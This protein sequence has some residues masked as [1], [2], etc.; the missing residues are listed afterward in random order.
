M[1]VSDYR[2]GEQHSDA[3]A[4][5][6]HERTDERNARCDAEG[7]PGSRQAKLPEK[8]P[9]ERPAQWRADGDGEKNRRE[10][11]DRDAGDHQSRKE[12]AVEQRSRERKREGKTAGNADP[13]GDPGD[14][15]AQ[16]ETFGS[17]IPNLPRSWLAR[18]CASARDA[19]WR[20]R[21]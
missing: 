10:E 16:P 7:R 3:G 6:Q 14:G 17:V 20:M 2:L 11:G 4:G 12:V 9:A 13:C 21:T 8:L 18:A 1:A 5:E 19:S 15:G